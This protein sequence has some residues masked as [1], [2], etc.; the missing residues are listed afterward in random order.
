ML[1]YYQR[2]FE[3]NRLIDFVC[4]SP[5]LITNILNNNHKGPI[6]NYPDHEISFYV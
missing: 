2:R 4:N 3:L 6:L 5:K 1:I